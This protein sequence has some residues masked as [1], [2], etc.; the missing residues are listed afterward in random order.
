M[1]DSQLGCTKLCRTGV[2]A[3]IDSNPYLCA[4]QMLVPAGDQMILNV[5]KKKTSEILKHDSTHVS[6]AS[7]LSSDKFYTAEISIRI[8][9]I[10]KSSR[11]NGSKGVLFSDTRGLMSQIGFCFVAKK[12]LQSPLD[13]HAEFASI[14]AAHR[15]C[16]KSGKKLRLAPFSDKVKN[17]L[18]R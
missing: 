12:R 6:P 1:S 13:F 8:A 4:L 7:S 14:F 11:L 15:Y 10:A 2:L 18:T 3:N 5:H 9:R 16:S 17:C